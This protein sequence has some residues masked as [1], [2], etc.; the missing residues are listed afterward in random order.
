MEL[1][2]KIAAG[3]VTAALCAVMLRKNGPEFASVVMLAAGVWILT[4][5]ARALGE[6]V[7]AL[8][9]LAR[10]ARL[11]NELVQ[12]VVKV[13]GLSVITRVAGESCRGAGEAGIAAFVEVSG[14]FLALA[15]AVP[16]VNAVVEMLSEMLI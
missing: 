6:T 14:V 7:D 4:M 5:A 13:V 3:A 16:L 9:R 2:L 12:P 1:M 8:S 15:S 10:I 11:E